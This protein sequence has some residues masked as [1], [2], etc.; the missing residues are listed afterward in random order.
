MHIYKAG[1]SPSPSGSKGMQP[2]GFW[3]V[4]KNP[5][6]NKSRKLWFFDKCVSY[7]AS[8][9]ES[10]FQIE[11]GQVQHWFDLTWNYLISFNYVTVVRV[12]TVATEE[13]A[14]V[15]GGCQRCAQGS[16]LSLAL[17]SLVLPHWGRA[18]E[19]QAPAV[20]WHFSI[21][22]LV[23]LWVAV[24]SHPLNRMITPVKSQPAVTVSYQLHLN[25]MISLRQII[26]FLSNVEIRATVLCDICA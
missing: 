13:V 8:L 24:V 22:C 1:V 7:E 9:L 4:K 25:L 26:N 15:D 14:Q 11:E 2:A 5:I 10:F 16:I 12:C 3:H 17:Q 18:K 23:W 6:F 20:A 21:L 19:A